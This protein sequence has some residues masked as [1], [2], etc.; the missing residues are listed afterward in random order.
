MNAKSPAFVKL[1]ELAMSRYESKESSA[2]KK[3]LTLKP[4]SYVMR[5]TIEMMNQQY[6]DQKELQSKGKTRNKQE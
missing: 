2:K 1:E 6:Y 4:K 3:K 5:K